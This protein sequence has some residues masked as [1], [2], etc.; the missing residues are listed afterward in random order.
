VPPISLLPIGSDNPAWLPQAAIDALRSA[1]VLYADESVQSLAPPAI[2][3]VDV[4]DPGVACSQMLHDAQQGLRVARV[5]FR[6]RWNDPVVLRDV[7]A[8]R[9]ASLPFELVPSVD[10]DADGWAAWLDERPLFGRCVAVL[11]MA[12]QAS[13]TA[14]LL[15][16]RGADPWVVPTIE[17][18]PPADREP[19]L[20]ALRNLASYDLVA[21]TS[22]N[23]VDRTFEE[24]RVL[25][26]DARA[27]GPCRVAAIGDATAKRL[28]DHGIF[29]DVTAKVF[30]GE[31]LADSIL[32]LL[33]DAKGKRVLVPRALEAREVLPETLRE[34]GAHADVV[35]AYRTLPP[36]PETVA[37]LREALAAGK[38]D[39]ILLT[40]S[41]T[42]T[43]LC[44]ALGSDAPA[45]LATSCLA[46]I[47]PITTARAR[48]LGLH[49]RVEA[50]TFTVPGV[51]E[52]LETH[53]R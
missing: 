20:A 37:P 12:G 42:V 2:R 49:V 34:A 9:N 27:L 13:A 7:R 22:T 17:L 33:G 52:A 4:H 25:G 30:R 45:L 26:L 31:A 51:V 23:G 24:L 35:P 8:L 46:S 21:F 11:R 40:S 5:Y 50:A 19:L 6:I 32:E 43:N 10:P 38:V 16:T 15:R 48:D 14:D 36:V 18:H 47:G 53:F 44:A 1:D 39:A 29:A 28:T 41:S 3:R